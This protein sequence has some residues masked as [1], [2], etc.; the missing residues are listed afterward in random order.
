MAKRKKFQ[1]VFVSSLWVLLILLV[2]A[3][4]FQQKTVPAVD[5]RTLDGK[6]FNTSHINNNGKPI[7][8]SFWATWCKPC[9]KELEAMAA[10]YAEWNKETQVKIV[11]VSIDDSR[12]T[13]RA[14]TEAKAKAWEFDVYLDP[15][16]DFKRAM[17]VNNIPHTFLLDGKGEI[18]WQHTAYAEGDEDQLYELVKKYAT[19]E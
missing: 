14:A 5:I 4:S 18:V 17:N 1:I 15:N 9:K 16:Q 7:I 11:A 13:A 12:S 2:S 6:T 3:T 10:N 8:I 19:K